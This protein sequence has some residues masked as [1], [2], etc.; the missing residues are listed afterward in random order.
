METWTGGH[1][2]PSYSFKQNRN[3]SRLQVES[4]HLEPF[5]KLMETMPRKSAPEAK[6][7]LR[8]YG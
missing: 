4:S 3:T 8:V 2:F 7:S 1:H 5:P 6:T